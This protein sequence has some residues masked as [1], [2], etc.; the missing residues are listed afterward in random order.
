[1]TIVVNLITIAYFIDGHHNQSMAMPI[2]CTNKLFVMKKINWAILALLLF[3]VGCSSTKITTAWK[4]EN[5]TPHRYNKILVLGLINDKDR[6]I[7]ERM[8]QHFVGDL[9]NLGYNAVS[10]L[11][12]YGP[13]AFENLDENAALQKIKSSGADAVVTIVLLDKKKV[14]KYVPAQPIYPFR[15]WE[16]YGIRYGSIYEPG[17]YVNDTKYF[18]ESNFYDMDSQSML[19]SVQTK[20]FSPTSTEEM[21]HE[22]GKTIV[23]DM[24]KQKILS[25]QNIIKEE[26]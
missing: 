21:G 14:R 12:Q 16:Y 20:S 4:A 6:R 9:T 23:K 7:Q 5:I 22:Y 3:F 15:F 24:L 17:Y 8:E 1:M 25:P 18:W 13:K 26:N 2:P 10:A 19:Y 11:Q